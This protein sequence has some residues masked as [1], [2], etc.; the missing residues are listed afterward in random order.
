MTG[1]FIDTNILV[2]ADD[3]DTPSKRHKA[4]QIIADALKNQTGIVS[5]QV[6]QEYYVIAT[7][8]LKIEKEIVQRKVELFMALPLIRITETHIL[9]AIKLHRLY[10][11]SYWDASVIYAAKSA[12]CSELLTE[13]MQAGRMIEGI[14]IVNPFAAN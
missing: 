14:R 4:Q 8:K 11:L 5:T 12:S 1:F 9:E 2:Y 10:P 6:I 3:L 13:D 7:Q